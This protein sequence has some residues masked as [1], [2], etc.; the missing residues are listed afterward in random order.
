MSHREEAGNTQDYSTFS[1]FR[2]GLFQF[3]RI[4]WCP[5]KAIQKP[6]V[7]FRKKEKKSHHTT[8]LFTTCNCARAI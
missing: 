5:N 3:G 7:V 4:V 6:D 2:N 8:Q 1:E